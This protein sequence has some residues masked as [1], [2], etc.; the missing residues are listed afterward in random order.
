MIIMA[1]NNSDRYTFVQG[2]F[3]NL[4]GFADRI[5]DNFCSIKCPPTRAPTVPTPAPTRYVPPGC[6]LLCS[7]NLEIAFGMLIIT[8]LT[9]L[10]NHIRLMIYDLVNI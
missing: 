8:K 2:G 7:E 5:V 1:G 10:F 4:P 3:A 6:K 9:T